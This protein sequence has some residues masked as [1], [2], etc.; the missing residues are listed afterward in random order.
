[1]EVIEEEDEQEDPDEE[2][3]EIEEAPRRMRASDLFREKDDDADFINDDPD[4]VIGEPAELESIPL[5]FSSLS[6]AKPRELFKYAVEWMVQ[7]KINPAFSS[8]DEI[9]TLAFR[10]LDD[11]VNGLANSKYSS[12]AWT[13]DFTRA[14]RARPEIFINEIGKMER[15]VMDH[16]CEACNRRSHPGTFT[17][18]FS[19]KPYNK[20]TLEPLAEEDSDSSSDS[21]LSSASESSDRHGDKKTYDAQ[22]ELIPPESKVFNVG[23]TCKANA[24]MAHT[25]RHWRYHLNSWVVDYLVRMGHCT[26]E[27]LVKRDKWSQRKREKAANKIVDAMETSGEIR[28]LHKLYKDQVDFAVEAKNEYTRGWGRR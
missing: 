24:Q 10:K 17:I 12:A 25:L 6:R 16:H 9:Y 8:T 21:E 2:E 18:T 4:A 14:L 5:E 19:G 11:E 7:K 23:S 26:P 28:K 20:E 3:E 15:S 1:L 27:K 22:G 13:S